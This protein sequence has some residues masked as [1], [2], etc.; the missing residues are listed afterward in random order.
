VKSIRTLHGK[1]KG[2][3]GE[4]PGFTTRFFAEL[5][6]NRGSAAEEVEQDGNYGQHQQDMNESAGNVER[7]KTQQPEDQENGGNDR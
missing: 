7:G 6:L 5:K 2:G 1:I 4:S 3:S